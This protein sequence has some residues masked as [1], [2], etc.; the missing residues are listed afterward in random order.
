MKKYTIVIL[1]FVFVSYFSNCKSPNSTST[2][3]EDSTILSPE[4]AIKDFKIED[5]FEIQTIASEPLIE[6][7]VAMGFDEDG[8]MYF[9]EM[10]GYMQNEDGAGE[11][12]PLGRI[13][14]LSDP[15][16]DGIYDKSKIF[17]DSLVMP[18]AVAVVDGGI[19][20]I[21]PPKLL[22][23]RN[24]NGVAGEQ[25]V[26]D[27]A[28]A[29]AGNVEHQPNGLLR[30]M[31]NW[32]YSAKSDKRIRFINNKW[33]VEKTQ[34]RGQWGI[35]EDDNGKL[36]YNENST[37]LLGDNF[38]PNVFAENKN[39]RRIS[40]NIYSVQMASNKVFPAVKTYVNRGYEPNMLDSNGKL[41]NVSAA[42]GPVIY[43]GDN[44]PAA[45]YGNAFVPEP[46]AN[47]IKRLILKEDSNHLTTAYFAYQNRE[48]LTATDERFRPV[49]GYNSPD[50]SL[51]FIDMHRGIIQHTT[52][53]TPYLRKHIDSMHLQRPIG[54]GRLYRVKWKDNPLSKKMKLSTLSSPDLVT[55]LS[56]KNGWYRDMA[57]R[58]LVD[59]QDT[60]VSKILQ[61]ILISGK[62]EHVKLHSLYTLEG[63]NKLTPA[64][65]ANFA[66]ANKSSVVYTS[67]M[68]LLEG[69]N[70]DKTALD[71]L[72]K[73]GSENDR[74]GKIQLANSLPYFK[75]NFLSTVK[76][77]QAKL[78]TAFSKDTLIVDAIAGSEEGKEENVIAL[79]K[80]K[81]I[82]DTTWTKAIAAAIDRR[83]KSLI[84]PVAD[85]NPKQREL[86]YAGEGNFKTFCGTC[87]GQNGEGI[88]K[89]APHLAGSNWAMNPDSSI[90]I[91][92]VLD[93]L[94]GSINVTDKFYGP[95][96][97]ATSMPGLRYN[98]ETNNGVVASVI[99]YI[100]NAWG[101]K[102]NPVTVENVAAI[103][104]ATQ[105]RTTSY[106]EPELGFPGKFQ[107]KRSKNK[108]SVSKK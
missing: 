62:P 29:N 15:D 49:N 44:F 54:M 26:I 2:G 18:R 77:N 100:R 95:P 3:K 66:E 8:N 42:C 105:Q 35:T 83:K 108:V 20:V 71:I 59:R 7:P 57:Q 98:I 82:S 92:I 96:D 58:L 55:L 90:A 37:M 24:D 47:M 67:C 101:N 16:D 60:S 14:I 41:N 13:K 21:A 106:T 19:L 51:I 79:L 32:I 89:V 99:T 45:Y 70:T 5:G 39:Y 102:A 86:Y 94:T 104:A 23:V 64:L 46:A 17:M 1:L 93:G 73:L 33:V 31:D 107:M 80:Q 91:R 88:P 68:K 9:V 6:D 22:F 69:F 38:L 72:L 11:N 36:Y 78:I 75:R 25:S 97:Y 10:R 61:D 27:S 4:Q 65:L 50:G 34:F 87:H 81:K 53:L 74:P 63:L 48:F 103:R 56:H 52:Y 43:R 85:L 12:L 30:A 40:R 84:D 28:F 76:S